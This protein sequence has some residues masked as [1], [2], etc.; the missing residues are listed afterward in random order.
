MIH[1]PPLGESSLQRIASGMHRRGRNSSIGRP[2]ASNS[3]RNPADRIADKTADEHG[4]DRAQ[5]G[6]QTRPSGAAAPKSS[7][8]AANRAAAGKNEALLQRMR[9]P[10]PAPR[11]HTGWRPAPWHPG[12]K[13][14]K[15]DR[16]NEAVFGFR[17]LVATTARRR[18]RSRSRRKVRSSGR[19]D[20][21][22]P[23]EGPHQARG[24]EQ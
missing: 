18:C 12:I 23:N 21:S 14:V 3:R 16:R 6:D 8:S 4:H 17:Q 7:G 5:P 22:K 10:A 20:P 24:P 15:H 1:T 9:R 2:I 19:R 11:S 13:T